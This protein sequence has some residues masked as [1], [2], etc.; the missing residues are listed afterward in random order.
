MSCLIWL[1]NT[2]SG[3]T[4]DPAPDLVIVIEDVGPDQSQGHDQ[5]QGQGHDPSQRQGQTR[6]DPKRRAQKAGRK[7]PG[8]LMTVFLCPFWL[9][10]AMP[11]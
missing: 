9:Q 6:R 7:N 11:K 3:P 10:F 8:R 2:V 1:L 4:Q 5:G